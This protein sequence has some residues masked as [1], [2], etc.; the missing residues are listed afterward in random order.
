M[1]GNFLPLAEIRFQ[2]CALVKSFT[3]KSRPC[4]GEISGP[5]LLTLPSLGT[6]RTLPSFSDLYR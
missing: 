2:N 1:E 3:L 4:C 6:V 5:T